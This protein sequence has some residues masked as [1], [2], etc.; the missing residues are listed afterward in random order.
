M[1]PLPSLP[2]RF[3][4]L[5]SE[6]TV[7]SSHEGVISEPPQ[8]PRQVK[9]AR[10][11][12]IRDGDTLESLSLRYL[13][14]EGRS[15]EIYDAN[16]SVLNDPALLPIGAELTIPSGDRPAVAQA[17]VTTSSEASGLVPLPRR[18]GR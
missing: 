11:H 2:D 5:E 9:R 15:S 3:Q 17:Q 4:P 7:A 1:V 12:K 6:T 16:R 8:L 10:R 14:D 18:F 13:D